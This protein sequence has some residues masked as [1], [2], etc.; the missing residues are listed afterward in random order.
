MNSEK[1]PAPVITSHKVFSDPLNF[2][3]AL[4]YDIEN[5]QKYIYIEI[6]K[7]VD[8]S[9]G[10]KFRDALTKKSS[11]GVKIK[12]LLDSWGTSLPSGYFAELIR[13]DGELR[14]FKKLRYTFDAFTKHH[15]RNHRKIIVIDDQV[16]Y[17]GSAN[18]NDYS[19]NWRELIVRMEGGISYLF[20][21]AFNQNWKIYD[22]L[23][24]GLKNQTRLISRG[25]YKLI[26]DVP[27]ITKQKIRSKLMYLIKHAQNEIYIETPYF[28]PGFMLRK[29]LM[30]AG[31]RGV[32]VVV[33]T[34]YQS[35]VGIVDVLR[36]KYLGMLHKSNVSIM[37]YK[38]HNLHAKLMIT[39]GRIF[40][41]GS[42]N[43][44]YRSFRYMFEV[45]L[46]GSDEKLMRDLMIHVNETLEDSIPFDY[47]R[48]KNRPVI[49][50]V[51]EQLLV[52][53]RHL[54]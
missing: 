46:M 21:H 25:E 17:L 22:K 37:F 42:A 19:L 29:A 18:I 13:N 48:W 27:S 9:I 5:A 6:F 54:L 31:K 32:K 35:D 34:P 4:L 43:F 47:E 20:K 10:L 40:C 44:D 12:L 39:D 30:D 11:Q 49:H 23:V 33:I 3:T 16:S 8:D 14:Y 53:F 26:R 7:F 41:F 24:F 38:P 28:L 2:Y 51:F 50:R 36:S 1:A 45:M 15:R 52:P